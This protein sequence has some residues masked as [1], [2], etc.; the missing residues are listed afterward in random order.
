MMNEI[1][2]HEIS[3]TLLIPSLATDE[4]DEDEVE[5]DDEVE[6]EDE[7]QIQKKA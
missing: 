7:I 4:V 5:A 3:T 6:V 2:L 1:K